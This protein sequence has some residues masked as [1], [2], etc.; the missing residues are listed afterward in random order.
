MESGLNPNIQLTL[1][2]TDVYASCDT[3]KKIAFWERK[4]F[5]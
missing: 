3:F 5:L 4:G 2:S 1:P